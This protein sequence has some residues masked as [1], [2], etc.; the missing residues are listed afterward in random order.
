M[1][2]NTPKIW[3]NSRLLLAR[4]E[5]VHQP[6]VSV[7]DWACVFYIRCSGDNVVFLCRL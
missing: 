6:I 2:D 4:Y 5:D 3:K 1:R 7:L